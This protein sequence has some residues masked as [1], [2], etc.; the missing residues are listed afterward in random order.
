[1]AAFVRIRE[2]TNPIF[3]EVAKMPVFGTPSLIQKKGNGLM[4]TSKKE[5]LEVVGLFLARFF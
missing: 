1:M 2:E 4:T 3:T 5:T